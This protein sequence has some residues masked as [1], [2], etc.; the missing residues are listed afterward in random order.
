M[1]L[2]IIVDTKTMDPLVETTKKAKLFI[3]NQLSK[4][5]DK[6]PEEILKE[7]KDYEIKID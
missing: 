4:L 5:I 3:I 7:L 1:E 6:T 2:S